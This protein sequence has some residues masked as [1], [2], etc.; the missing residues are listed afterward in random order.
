MQSPSPAIMNLPGWVLMRASPTLVSPC[1]SDSIPVATPGGSSPSL[2]NDA[3]RIRFSPVG[4][5]TVATTF[6]SIMPTKLYDVVEPVVLDV[7][8]VAAERRAVG[9]QHALG[10]GRGD[11]DERTDGEGAVADVDRLGLGD[12][13]GVGEVDVAVPGRRQHRAEG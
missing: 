9:E 1:H 4:T 7:E 5:S 6:C 10:A 2:S 3:D 12:L 11:V 8:G 13:G